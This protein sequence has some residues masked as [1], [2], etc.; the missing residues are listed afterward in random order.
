MI[1]KFYFYDFLNVLYIEK[2]TAMI[3]CDSIK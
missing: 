2:N 1:I 3:I